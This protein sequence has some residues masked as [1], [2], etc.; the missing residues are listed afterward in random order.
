MEAKLYKQKYLKSEAK[1][2][3]KQQK[4]ALDGQVI[5]ERIVAVT[6]KSGSKEYSVIRGIGMH[7]FFISSSS[8]GT[9]IQVEEEAIE[10]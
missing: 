2:I 5:G 10:E 8:L 7:Y 4:T 3:Y 6:Q 1:I 9:A